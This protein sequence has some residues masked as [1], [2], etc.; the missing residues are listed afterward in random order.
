MDGVGS[1]GGVGGTQGASGG[2]AELTPDVIAELAIP[3][4]IS[5]LGQF[6]SMMQQALNEAKNEE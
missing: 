3:T 4:S 1:V 6:R 2:D 5:L